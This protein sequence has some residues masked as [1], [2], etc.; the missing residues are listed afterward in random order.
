MRLGHGL[1]GRSNLAFSPDWLSL[2]EPA[3]MEARDNHLLSLAAQSAGENPVIVDLGCGTGST[4]RAIQPML[5]SNASW[6]LVDNDKVL[7]DIAKSEAPSGST[8]HE[9]DLLE[10]G[11]LPIADASLITASALLDLVSFDW[12]GAFLSNISVPVYFALTYDGD[13]RWDPESPDDELIVESFNAHQ[14]TDKGFGNALGS[15]APGRTSELL[16]E[17]GFEVIEAKSPWRLTPE[18]SNLQRELLTGI[19]EAAAFGQPELSETWLLEKLSNLDQLSCTV[20]H[21]DIIAFP[22]GYDRGLVNA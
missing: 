2:R 8:T 1:R 16:S 15:T 19:S 14:Q 5:S 21:T 11:K 3:D 13:M 17:L 9:Q 6:R 7:L 10:T 12:L 20:G 4:V 18:Q 22:A